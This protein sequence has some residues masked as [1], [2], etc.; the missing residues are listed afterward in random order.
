MTEEQAKQR[1]LVLTLVRVFALVMVF[2]GIAN[3]G[4]RL[5]PDLA[6]VLGGV[7]LVAGA[8]DFFLAPALLKK[9]WRTQDQ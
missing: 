5:F 2:A 9:H 8:A 6:P 4:G 3:L 1:F 7:L